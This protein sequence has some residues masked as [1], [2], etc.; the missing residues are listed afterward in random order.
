M[1]QF[2][3]T[4]SLI[5]DSAFEK[6]KN[7]TVAVFGIG[8]VGGYVVEALVR[9]GVG[10]IDVIDNDI[11]LGDTIVLGSEGQT[12]QTPVNIYLCLNGKTITAAKSKQVFQIYSGYTLNICDCSQ[13]KTGQI[14]G[15]D[16]FTG[17]GGVI[18]ILQRVR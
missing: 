13:E 15:N 5:G 16:K 2:I 14:R 6:L 12:P 18:S 17:S 3:R 4:K 1:E 9:A 11:T 10:K 7:P 8:G